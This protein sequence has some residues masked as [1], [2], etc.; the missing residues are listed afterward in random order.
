MAAFLVMCLFA[1]IAFIMCIL[2]I[3]F[4]IPFEDHRHEKKPK[5]WG[6][7]FFG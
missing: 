3:K 1:L 5:S 2:I 4:G 7:F 6:D